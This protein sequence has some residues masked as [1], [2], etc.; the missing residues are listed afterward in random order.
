MKRSI[1]AGSRR[2]ITEIPRRV[3]VV[4]LGKR[5]PLE[6]MALETI[7]SSLEYTRRA[8]GNVAELIVDDARCANKPVTAVS[9]GANNR[10][11][12]CR[13]RTSRL[14]EI[15]SNEIGYVG[16]YEHGRTAVAQH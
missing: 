12:P 2:E 8:P 5:D 15:V 7:D 14:D 1:T 16:P 10:V 13:E 6:T 11:S 4:P 3:D 9:H